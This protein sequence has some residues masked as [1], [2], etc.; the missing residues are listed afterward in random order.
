MGLGLLPVPPGMQSVSLGLREQKPGLLGQ[1]LTGQGRWGG[2]AAQTEEGRVPQSPGPVLAEHGFLESARPRPKFCIFNLLAL[3]PCL[4]RAM[5][6][7]VP[8]LP[9]L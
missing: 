2:S 4:V 5:C 3:W 1:M 7:S 9:D 6:L 8:Q